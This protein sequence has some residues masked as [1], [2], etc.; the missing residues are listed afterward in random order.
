MNKSRLLE[1]KAD[2]LTA[3]GFV[4]I[5]MLFAGL[6]ADYYYD[7][8]DDVLIKDILAGVQTGT[9]S[10]HSIQMLYPAGFFI[11]LLYR[12]FR[13]APWYGIF[14]CACQYLSVFLIAYRCLGMCSG[15]ERKSA[16]R[17]IAGKA[18]ALLLLFLLLL[19]LFFRELVFVQYSVTGAFLAGT[20]A[21]WL[22]TAPEGKKTP[23]FWKEAVVSVLLAA[24]AFYIRT[25]MLLL[26]LP[27]LCA[28]GAGR[29]FSEAA[30]GG[31]GVWKRFFQ[32]ELLCR[33]AAV[34]GAL[35]FGMAAGLLVDSMARGSASWREFGRFFDARTQIYDF[36]G[37]PDYEQNREFYTSIG[38]GPAGQELL[39]NYNFGFD[40]GIDAQ[41]LERLE[42][43]AGELYRGK[44]PFGQSLREAV[45]KLSHR[46]LPL[47][48]DGEG[49]RLFREDMPWNLVI[50]L[51]YALVLLA[52]C[53]TGKYDAV[54]NLL[55]LFLA[56]TVSWVY[57][58][59]RDRAPERITHSLYL[60]EV[61]VLGAF[62]AVLLKGIKAGVKGTAALAGL[63]ALSLLAAVFIPSGMRDA[64]EEAA[65]REEKNAPY[66]SL[67]EYCGRNQEHYYYVDVRSTVDFSEKM[68]EKVDNSG[69]NYDIIGGWACKSPLFREPEGG[70]PEYFIIRSDKETGWLTDFYEEKDRT[71]RL[72]KQDTAGELNAYWTVYRLEEQEEKR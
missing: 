58:L 21:F 11:S 32:K 37:I 27:F 4:L 52:A 29:W 28:A 22:Y 16:A 60:A 40:A 2:L 19:S 26:L 71:V 8:N 67:L 20:A 17:E 38:M 47:S 43:R 39:E 53:L 65:L 23:E 46:L 6:Y 54:W 56:R 66:R 55:L 62:L 49:G 18:A 14:L 68:F 63:A 9:P 57:I 64:G 7:L 24:L 36:Y 69:R 44:H 3:A 12:L 51:L 30:A 45:W 42:E 31:R 50:A 13:A 33:Y 25:E 72:V 59:Y 61:F 35:L 15:G 5:L 10:G 70:L 48:S 1:K 34:I 41:L